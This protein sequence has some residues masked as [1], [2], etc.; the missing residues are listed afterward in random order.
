VAQSL[1]GTG[2]ALVV[3]DAGAAEKAPVNIKRPI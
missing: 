1:L 3:G 2:E